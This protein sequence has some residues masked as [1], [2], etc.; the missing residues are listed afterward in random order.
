MGFGEE[1]ERERDY[2]LK[3]VMGIRQD[4]ACKTVS[5]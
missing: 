1:G 2:T 3:V 4:N 5:T